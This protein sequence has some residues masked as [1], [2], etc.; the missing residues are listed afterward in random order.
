MHPGH[1]GTCKGSLQLELGLDGAGW[2]SLSP[3]AAGV[4][5]SHSAGL[6]LSQSLNSNWKDKSLWDQ[7]L[8]QQ[9]PSQYSL[10]EYLK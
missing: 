8:N 4:S 9:L 10:R 2:S 5:R 6:E 7:A 1:A 3:T